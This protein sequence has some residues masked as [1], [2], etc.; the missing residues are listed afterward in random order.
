M[1]SLNKYIAYVKNETKDLEELEKVRWIYIDLGKRFSFDLKFSHGGTSTQRKIYKSSSSPKKLEECFKNNIGI[2]KSIAL[3]FEKVLKATG[4]KCITRAMF[5]DENLC[6]HVNNIITL[7]DGRAFFADLQRDLENI[8]THSTTRRFGILVGTGENILSR[9]EMEQIDKKIKYIGP[10]K[11]YSDEYL[12]L[13]KSDMR[14]FDKFSDMA[15]FVITN[16]EP[17]YD[18]DIKYMERKNHHERLLKNLFYRDELQKI[19]QIDCYYKIGDERVFIPSIY[20]DSDNQT[21]IYMFDDEEQRYKRVSMGEFVEKKENG[22]IHLQG[23]PR[24]R[25]FLKK[26]DKGE[27]RE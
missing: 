8:Q 17:I 7:K 19:H 26:R 9:F 10:G 24:L 2:C 27:V 22:L 20:V 25:E 11:Y 5:D 18:T 14:L 4:T 13:L 16:L 23:I 12:Y 6:P 1:S 3:I 15:E 21:S